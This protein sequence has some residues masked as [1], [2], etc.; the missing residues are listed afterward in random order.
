MTDIY[1]IAQTEV[2]TATAT[3]IEFTSIPADYDELI[4]ILSARSNKSSTTDN[5]A[6]TFNGSSAAYYGLILYQENS[7]TP[8][9]AT[10]NNASSLTTLYATGDTAAANCFSTT[11]VHI[12]GYTSTAAKAFTFESST[13]NNSGSVLQAFGNG[14][15]NNSSTISSLKLDPVTGDFMQFSK[16]TLYGVLSGSD[17]STSGSSS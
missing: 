14:V 8:A 16:A 10:V 6:L 5:I 7:G 2:E 4:L 9:S 1:F 13:T 15:W 12:S 3:D 11:T 17:G